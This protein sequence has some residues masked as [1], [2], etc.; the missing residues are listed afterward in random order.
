[1]SNRRKEQSKNREKEQ[2]N[3]WKQKAKNKGKALRKA[4]RKIKKLSE[5]G[6]QLKKEFQKYKES[7]SGAQAAPQKPTKEKEK[8]PKRYWFQ[9]NLIKVILEG[10]LITSVSFRA[11]SQLFSIFALCMNL[12]VRTPSHTT[13]MNWVHKIGLYQLTRK[14][15]KADDWVILLD[16]SIQLGREKLFV[17]LGIRES[18]IDFTRPLRFQDLVPLLL[19]AKAKWNLEEARDCLL[20]VKAEVGNIIYAVGDYGGDIKKGLELAEIKH[21]H[22]LG[23]RIALILQ[24]IY[25]KNEIFQEFMRE[26]AQMNKKLAQTEFAFIIPPK[27][28]EKSR[29][30]N[31]GKIITWAI[32]VLKRLRGRKIEKGVRDKIRWVKKYQ[33][34]IEELSEINA[35]T[36]EI[37]K[38]L[39]S[40]GLSEKTVKR[41]NRILKNLTTENGKIVAKEIAEYLK[42]SI[43]LLPENDTI[44]CSSDIIESSFGKYKNYLSNNSMAG[45]TNLVLCIAAFTCS[46][47]KC[48]IK[49]ALET[50]TVA[51]VKCWT[52]KNVG[53]TLLQKRR[54]FLAA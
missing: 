53:K 38:I 33:Q 51:D 8:K 36:R 3:R 7:M 31:I 1:M 23:H 29:F 2:K 30:Q 27:R 28:K 32:K 50:T 6:N 45:I 16:H 13:V 49:E 40:N 54:E 9:L 17:V 10:K 35:V 14:K 34:L 21:V 4:N 46:L 19:V 15:K 18:E 47:E 26:L 39:K 24:K 43:S 52:D 12:N 22:D 25:K 5:E 48:E 42:E 11:I 37:E 41:C 20:E 44:L